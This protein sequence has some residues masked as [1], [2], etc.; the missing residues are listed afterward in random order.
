MSITIA[1]KTRVD[2]NLIF[3]H[4]DNLGAI[5]PDAENA[6]RVTAGKITNERSCLPVPY[7]HDGVVAATDDPFF[8]HTHASH[9]SSVGIGVTLE[10]EHPGLS[11]YSTMSTGTQ[12]DSMTTGVTHA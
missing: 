9:K 2:T 1:C 5:K 4:G 12:N 10:A 11:R 7:L 8:I 6:P 3:S